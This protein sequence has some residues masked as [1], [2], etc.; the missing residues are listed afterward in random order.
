MA[1]GPFTES[2]DTVFLR[3]LFDGEVS[4]ELL[5]ASDARTTS[6]RFY[7][8]HITSDNHEVKL[9][10]NSPQFDGDVPNGSQTLIGINNLRMQIKELR[11]ELIDDDD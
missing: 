4:R 10:W 2:Y 6:G 8:P 9:Q 11:Y 7:L 1:S 3:L 5:G